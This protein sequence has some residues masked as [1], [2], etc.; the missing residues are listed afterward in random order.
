ME[1]GFG[2]WIV[3]GLFPK[4]FPDSLSEGCGYN[5][6]SDRLRSKR[7]SVVAWEVG[8]CFGFGNLED[9]KLIRDRSRFPISFRLTPLSQHRIQLD[10]RSDLTSFIKDKVRQPQF[11]QDNSANTSK[12]I[13]SKSSPTIKQSGKQLAI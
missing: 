7:Q 3:L 5:A 9:W 4:Q 1:D 6:N 13:S 8:I 2:N 11:V 10:K 12:E